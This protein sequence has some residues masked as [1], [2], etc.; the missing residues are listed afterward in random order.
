MQCVLQIRRFL[1]KPASIAA[2]LAEVF[3]GRAAG[4]ALENTFGSFRGEDLGYLGFKDVTEVY[5]PFPIETAG[6]D[7]T[8]T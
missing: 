2:S 6:D 3:C 7:G 1:F 4:E 5:D 8:V